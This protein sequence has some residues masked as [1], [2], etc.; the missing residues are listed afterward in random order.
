MRH[1]SDLFKEI[2]VEQT[3][4][5]KRKMQAELRRIT[6]VEKKKCWDIW[7]EVKIWV[8]DDKKKKIM[9]KELKKSFAE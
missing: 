9:I 4:D 3:P 7:K 8:A 5:N 6:G 1:L 2:G